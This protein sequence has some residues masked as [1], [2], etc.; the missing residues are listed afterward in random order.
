M[1]HKMLYMEVDFKVSTYR[2]WLSVQIPSDVQKIFADPACENL[3]AQVRQRSALL[4]FEDT[5]I[6]TMSHLQSSNFWI[7][8]R[9]V[10]DFTQSSPDHLLPLSGALS[11]MK[12]D[13]TRYVQLQS[14]YR[15]KAQRDLAVV[16]ARTAE[17]LASLGRAQDS[18]TAAEVESFCKFAQFIKVLKGR[19]LGVEYGV[20]GLDVKGREI[21]TFLELLHR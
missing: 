10:R 14:V 21:G 4:S 11:D 5:C 1:F 19:S 17:L 15:Q 13:T 16:Q 20:S 6:L 7:L 2:R 9:A 12:A 3:N 8:A 18:V